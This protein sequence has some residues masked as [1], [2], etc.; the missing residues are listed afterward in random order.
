MKASLFE[1]VLRSKSH[2]NRS[3]EMGHF[4]AQHTTGSQTTGILALFATL[5]G[6]QRR[7]KF[8]MPRQDRL[9]GRYVEWTGFF[10][11]HFR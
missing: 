7:A 8:T 1:I 9:K 11:F 2:P 3:S 4:C 6:G 5:P 10:R